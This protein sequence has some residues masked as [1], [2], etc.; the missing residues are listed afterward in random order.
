[1]SQFFKRKSQQYLIIV[2]VVSLQKN[3]YVVKV[4][5]LRILQDFNFFYKLWTL[6]ISSGHWH[7]YMSEKKMQ[8]AWKN[9]IWVTYAY[10]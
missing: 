3:T 6:I 8:K 9:Q 10:W 4:G 7:I 2:T 1:M 5:F